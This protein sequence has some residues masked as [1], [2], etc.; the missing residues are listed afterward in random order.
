VG[1]SDEEGQRLGE[2][3]L[4]FLDVG[5][6]VAPE[7]STFLPGAVPPAAA[8]AAF[9]TMGGTRPKADLAQAMAR[10]MVFAG[11]P[12]TVHRQIM[13]F[14]DR[15]G[16]FGHLVLMGRSGHMTHAETEKSIRLFAT[17]VMPRLTARA[18]V[19]AFR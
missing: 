14:Q 2:K 15:V 11:N 7:F 17:E 1:D 12:D 10:G 18:A 13:E 16:G 8:P 19:P 3:L 4:W 5:D 6:I 9:R